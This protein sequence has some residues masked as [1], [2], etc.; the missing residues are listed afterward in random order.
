MNDDSAFKVVV[1]PEPAPPDTITLSL[2]AT[3]VCK[4]AAISSVKAPNLTGSN[5]ELAEAAP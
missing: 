4:Y 2:V 5:A 1:L 3:A